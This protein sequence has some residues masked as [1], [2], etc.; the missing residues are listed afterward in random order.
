MNKKLLVMKECDIQP[1]D[2]Q[3]YTEA[4]NYDLSG[5]G[6]DGMRKMC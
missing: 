1:F 5:G 4:F 2:S 3:Q 6:I